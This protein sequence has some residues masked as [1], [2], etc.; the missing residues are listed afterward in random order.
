MPPWSLQSD[1]VHFPVLETL[2]IWLGGV[3]DFFKAIVTLRLKSLDY[4]AH[5]DS[6]LSAIFGGLGDKSLSQ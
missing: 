3:D 6:P 1:S 5:R 4:T 2:K